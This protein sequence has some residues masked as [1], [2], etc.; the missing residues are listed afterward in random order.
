MQPDIP[1]TPPETREECEKRRAR[2]LENEKW[3]VRLDRFV[4]AYE[5]LLWG[6]GGLVGSGMTLVHAIGV[7]ASD[8]ERCIVLY[9][10]KR[11]GKFNEKLGE[12][13]KIAASEPDAFRF[14]ITI[15]AVVEPRTRT[16]KPRR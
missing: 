8:T 6:A 5:G 13:R 3:R 11:T 7:R 2:E 16:W 9:L 12:L 15:E 1:D 14:A 10:E 4:A